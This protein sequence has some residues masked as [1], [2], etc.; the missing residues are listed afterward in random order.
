MK[1]SRQVL[2]AGASLALAAT[3]LTG[4]GGQEG[5]GGGTSLVIGG[6]GG[7]I[8]EATQ[9][10][11]LTPYKEESGVSV[12]FDDAPNTQLASLESQSRANNVTWDVLDSVA[13]DTAFLLE[14]KGLLEPLPDDLKARLV[15]A[16]GADKVTDFGFSHSNLGNVIVCNMDEMTTCPND[17]VEFFDTVKFPQT[18]ML[19][20]SGAIMMATAA[21][22]ASGVPVDQ[23]ATQDIDIDSVISTLEGI[24]PKVRVFWQSGDQQEQIMRSGEVAMGVMVSGRAYS[25][26]AEGMD[27]QINWSGGVYEPGYWAVPKNAPHKEEAFELLEWIATHPKAQ[28]QWAA[29]VHYSVPNPKA[30]DHMSEE[31]LVQFADTPANFE[32]LAVPNLSW[33]AEHSQELN[34]AFQDY[35]RG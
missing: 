25:L 18:R 15:E 5:P 23:T 29:E 6:W 14:A 19:S 31:L 7:S 20:G 34:Q 16:L 13:G 27:L 35:L 12:T 26:A 24:K 9:K 1:T 17:M 33:Y 11:Y 2:I 8:D 32:A 21:Q 10:A 4:C 30:R 3:T 22:V 28:A